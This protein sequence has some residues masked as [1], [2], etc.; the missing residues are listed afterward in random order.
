MLAFLSIE[1]GLAQGLA[2]GLF[3]TRLR[4]WQD[5]APRQPV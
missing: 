1:R 2:Q 4:S 5:A 3:S